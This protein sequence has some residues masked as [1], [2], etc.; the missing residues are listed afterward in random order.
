MSS[1]A[2]PK[3]W[4]QVELLRWGIFG[5]GRRADGKLRLG[6][7]RPV[8][9]CKLESS[10]NVR[11]C[12]SNFLKFGSFSGG[13]ENEPSKTW[14][15]WPIRQ[16]VCKG[17]RRAGEKKPK[18][19]GKRGP[20]DGGDGDGRRGPWPARRQGLRDHHGHP[21]RVPARLLQ[22]FYSFSVFI[23]TFSHQILNQ[24]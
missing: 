24:S 10:I 5:E 1:A 8:R 7:C 15:F 2:S 18:A 3:G 16:A 4:P 6:L 20:R 21:P 17:A 14:Q 12:F 19:R 23:S 9:P 13:L 22:T 11:K